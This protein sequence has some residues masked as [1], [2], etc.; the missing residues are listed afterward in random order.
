MSIIAALPSPESRPRP[1][2]AAQSQ[3]KTLLFD[4]CVERLCD[5]S[6][7]NIFWSGGS[8]TYHLTYSIN[9]AARLP[10]VLLQSSATE[11]QSLGKVIAGVQPRASCAGNASTE[12]R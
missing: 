5:W 1:P 7:M 12:Y 8:L 3:L 10:L 9:L 4:T 6:A 2:G 11:G